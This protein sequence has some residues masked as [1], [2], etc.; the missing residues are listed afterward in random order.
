MNPERSRVVYVTQDGTGRW[1]CIDVPS[2]LITPPT[3][4]I[5]KP[6]EGPVEF[7]YA[8]CYGLT[9]PREAAEAAGAGS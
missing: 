5:H 7:F 1:L 4:T 3:L 2:G 6:L 9:V 8:Q